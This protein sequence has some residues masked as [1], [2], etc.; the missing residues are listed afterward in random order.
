[1]IAL[2]YGAFLREFLKYSKTDLYKRIKKIYVDKEFKTSETWEG[3]PIVDSLENLEGEEYICCLTDPN[4]N[5]R[6]SKLADSKNLTLTK[7]YFIAKLGNKEIS[8]NIEIGCGT[9]IGPNTAIYSNTKIG[10]SCQ[11]VSHS[12]VSH[13]VE[14]GNF[15]MIMGGF[16]IIG[17]YNKIGNMNFFGQGAYTKDRIH[18]GDNCIVSMGAVVFKDIPSNH[19]AIGNPSKIIKKAENEYKV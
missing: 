10:D 1:M 19:I 3:I 17:G 6:M 2:G 8:K 11:I 12:L 16:S 14:I 9:I 5:Y 13:D 4:S 15:N 18:I 7:K